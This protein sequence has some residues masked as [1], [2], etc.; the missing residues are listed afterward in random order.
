MTTVTDGM[1]HVNTAVYE[2]GFVDAGSFGLIRCCHLGGR[3]WFSGKDTAGA[4]GH[5]NPRQAVRRYVDGG[6]KMWVSIQTGGGVHEAVMVS[7]QGLLM[8]ALQCHTKEARRFYRHFMEGV[9]PHLFCL[10]RKGG[11]TAVF[12][13]YRDGDRTSAE[14]GHGR[15]G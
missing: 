12:G 5:T 15:A 6:E 7:V 8:L 3:I 11:S 14:R 1:K 10:I 4:L 13:K 9:L 2:P